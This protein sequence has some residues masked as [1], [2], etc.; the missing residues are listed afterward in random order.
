MAMNKQSVSQPDAAD[1]LS[2]IKNSTQALSLALRFPVWVII[3]C[4]LSYGLFTYFYASMV[5]GGDRIVYALVSLIL[6]VLSGWC[7]IRTLRSRGF[8]VSVLPSTRYGLIYGSGLAV[9]LSL[10]MTGAS[11]YTSDVVMW[12]AYVGGC[13]NM[14]LIAVAQYCFPLNGIKRV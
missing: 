13:L 12:P 7:G 6:F 9:L 3:C 10:V 4:S 11:I 8:K 5:L 14:L 1:A 2:S